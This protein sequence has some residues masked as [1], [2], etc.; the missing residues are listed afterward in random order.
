MDSRMM[1]Q[2]LSAAALASILLPAAAA[3]QSRTDSTVDVGTPVRV[4]VAS[5]FR[6]SLFGPRAE[7]L[8]GTIRAISRDSLSIELPNVAGAVAIPR[9]SIRQVEIRVGESRR[10]GMMKAGTI[11]AVIF[12]LRMWAAHEEVRSRT[13]PETWQAVAVGGAIGFGAGAWFATRV[14]HEHWRAAHLRD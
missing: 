11:G 7:R 10:A 12:G 14:P 13:L 5:E 6:Q 2:F 9:A 3:A 1:R 8:R 4:T